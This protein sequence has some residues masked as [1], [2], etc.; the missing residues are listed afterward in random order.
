M[1]QPDPA[2]LMRAIAMFAGIASV[3]RA[4]GAGAAAATAPRTTAIAWADCMYG[5]E[6]QPVPP[7][8]AY[9][10]TSDGTVT[11]TRSW[12]TSPSDNPHAESAVIGPKRFRAIAEGI[13]RSGLFD[14]PTPRPRPSPDPGTGPRD[15]YRV[16]PSDTRRPRFAVRRDG[17]WTDWSVYREYSTSEHA[18]VGA[19]YEVARDANL[20]WRP[21]A[22]R[23]NA[24]A[25]C[26]YDA[27]RDAMTIPAPAPAPSAD[28]A[29]P[30]AYL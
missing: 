4:P 3:T 13:D 8:T 29:P 21:A 14:P 25:V 11:R 12:S 18:A 27:P 9:A 7:L 22:P 17:Q 19:A 30:H 24:F 16:A 28:G 1:D 2:T 6:S 15:I 23:A 5:L 10:L 20:V 26:Q